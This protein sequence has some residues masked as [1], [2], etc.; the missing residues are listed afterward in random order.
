M[1][2]KRC[3]SH[4]SQRLR[5]I[6]EARAETSR[7]LQVNTLERSSFF[8]QA[9]FMAT[10][11]IELERD[12]V[13]KLTAAK[14]TPHETFSDVVRRARFPQHPHLAHELREDFKRRAGHSPLSD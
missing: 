4:L 10:V 3:D 11:T 9:L 14:L 8:K 6:A 13:E 1:Q 5:E 7:D 12:A 2:M